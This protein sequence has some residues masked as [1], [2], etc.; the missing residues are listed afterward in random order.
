MLIIFH[1]RKK[2]MVALLQVNR[3]HKKRADTNFKKISEIEITKS[4]SHYA[5]VSS[6]V[7][8]NGKIPTQNEIINLIMKSTSFLLIWIVVACHKCQ[9]LIFVFFWCRLIRFSVD[10]S[11][12]QKIIQQLYA[13]YMYSLQNFHL[14]TVFMFILRNS[15]ANDWIQNESKTHEK[16]WNYTGGTICIAWATITSFYWN[17]LD[18]RITAVNFSIASGSNLQILIDPII[19]IDFIHWFLQKVRKKL[20]CS[21]LLGC[22]KLLLSQ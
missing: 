13:I 1:N 21:W 2:L 20:T 11:K 22:T 17:R 14:S 10:M 15:N 19:I 9:N 4:N 5:L 16:Q 8:F 18:Y 7:C 12:F 6:M 3:G